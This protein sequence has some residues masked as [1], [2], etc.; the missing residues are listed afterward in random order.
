MVWVG[1]LLSPFVVSLYYILVLLFPMAANV[2]ITKLFILVENIAVKISLN[3]LGLTL[4]D[5]QN[6]NHEFIPNLFS[7]QAIQS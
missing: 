4:Y 3:L 2:L 5:L 1:I 7:F 6:M